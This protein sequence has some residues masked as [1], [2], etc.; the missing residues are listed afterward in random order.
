MTV[1]EWLVA[2]L[3]ADAGVSALVSSRIYP[4]LLPEGAALPAIS[5]QTVGDVLH[6]S[7]S[8][9]SKLRRARVQITCHADT[10]AGAKSL[11]GAV[12]TS[13]AGYRGSGGGLDVHG[14]LVTN[15][16]DGYGGP[17]AERPVQRLDVMIWYVE[18]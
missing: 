9:N 4:L 8:G 5:Y 2:H 6:Y 15:I 16:Y 17:L 7:H 14:A 18:A 1:E 12:K 3:K 10:Y 13:L 11:A